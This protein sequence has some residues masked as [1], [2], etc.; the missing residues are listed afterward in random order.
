MVGTRTQPE[1]K[2]TFPR[3]CH[4]LCHENAEAFTTKHHVDRSKCCVFTTAARSGWAAHVCNKLKTKRNH[5]LCCGFKSAILLVSQCF[6]RR[7]SMPFQPKGSV[8]TPGFSATFACFRP[9]RIRALFFGVPI[10]IT[11][12][13]R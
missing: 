10:W 5:A 7:S 6:R 9:R 4:H 11:F 12:Q 2:P 1:R 3:S 13:S 8:F